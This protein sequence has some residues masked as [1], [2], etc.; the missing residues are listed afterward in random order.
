[1]TVHETIKESIKDAMRAKDAVRLDVLR[2]LSA[3]F[4]NEL[5]AK[6]QTPQEILADDAATAVI[7]RTIKQRRDSI[8][9]FTAGGRMDLVVEEQAQL[10]ILESLVP[11]MMSADEVNEVVKAKAAEL[12]VTDKS[13]MPKLMGAVMA[14]LKGKAD[15]TV[16]R[17]AVESLL[18]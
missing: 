3:A 12:G 6:G 7:Q 11:P 1:M 15:G 18:S 8:E 9:Q 2:G 17:Q 16:V 10:A 4:T 5:V 14:D 13:G